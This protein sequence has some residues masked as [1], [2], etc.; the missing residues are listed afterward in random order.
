MTEIPKD[1]ME[2]AR[3]TFE[4]SVDGMCMTWDHSFGLLDEKQ[5]DYLRRC[6]R[7]VGEHDVIPFTARAILAERNR[8]A[9]VA[10]KYSYDSGVASRIETEIEA[11]A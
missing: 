11:G 8:C 6:F 1:V 5:R 3:A 9:E 10:A 2:A 7:Q 4:S